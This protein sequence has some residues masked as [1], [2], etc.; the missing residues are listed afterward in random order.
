MTQ[1]T[2]KFQVKSWDEK[3]FEEIGSGAKLTR[4]SVSFSYQGDIEADSKVEYLM[5]YRED[6]TGNFV[7]L[8]RIVGRI[9][10]R[11]GSFIV[12]HN[13]TFGSEGVKVKLTI[14]PGS[15]T[16]DLHGLRGEGTAFLPSHQ[17]D[18]PLTLDFDFE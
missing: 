5:A 3:P 13:G 1:A 9:G 16:A 18:Y 17:Q 12:Q 4:A 7:G 2:A 11:S 10:D 15:G 8:E 14:M 6:G